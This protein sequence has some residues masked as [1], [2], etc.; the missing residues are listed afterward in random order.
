MPLGGEG[1]AVPLLVMQERTST[2]T[3]TLACRKVLVSRESASGT[4]GTEHHEHVSFAPSSDLPQEVWFLSAQSRWIVAARDH[5]WSR[6]T[7]PSRGSRH[8]HRDL[9]YCCRSNPSGPAGKQVIASSLTRMECLDRRVASPLRR[10]LGR[11]LGRALER[12]C[13][14]VAIQTFGSCR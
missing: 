1:E 4:G 12:V 14:E 11:A 8:N 13:S 5:H 2:I 3:S 7:V 10:V 9:V 6:E